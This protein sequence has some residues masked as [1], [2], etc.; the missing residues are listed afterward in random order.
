[1][2]IAYH[3]FLGIHR[4]RLVVIANH[5]VMM[6]PKVKFKQ[7]VTVPHSVCTSCDWNKK[8]VV[9]HTDGCVDRCLSCQGIVYRNSIAS[10]W[11]VCNLNDIVVWHLSEWKYDA[12]R[13]P[14]V[15]ICFGD[16]LFF[17]NSPCLG[18]YRIGEFVELKI[19][20]HSEDRKW[21][22]CACLHIRRLWNS[23]HVDTSTHSVSLVH[24][25]EPRINDA[26]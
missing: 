22:C 6:Q 1:M 3:L 14:F 24:C 10:F 26:K 23:L 12:S 11:F 7:I 25:S 5:T 13:H 21:I 8:T 4:S 17:W 9:A 19:G 16:L 2:V 15:P 18:T 20:N